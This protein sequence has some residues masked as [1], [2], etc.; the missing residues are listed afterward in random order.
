MPKITFMGAGSTAFAK[1]VL[2]DCMCVESLKGS[3][4]ALYDIDAGRLKDSAMMLNILNQSLGARMA[5]RPYLGKS[6]RRAA[7]QNADYVI[8]AVQV[9]GYKPSTVLDFKIPKKYGLLQTIGDTV[10]IGGIFRALRTM[11]VLLDFARDIEAVAP[12]A[13]MLNYSN[14]M[15][16]NMMALLRGSAARCVGLCHSV[17]GCAGTLLRHFG[18]QPKKLRWKVAGINHQIGRAHV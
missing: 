3:T 15:A 14:P 17:E 8:S 2:G 18:L 7:L 13:L 4:L 12:R 11:P 1:S 16:M 6:N 10:G 9:G 5:I